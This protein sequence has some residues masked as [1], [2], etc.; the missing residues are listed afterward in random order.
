MIA[1]KLEQKAPELKG[2]VREGMFDEEQLEAIKK[3]IKKKTRGN[4]FSDIKVK[5]RLYRF[6][7]GKRFD[8]HLIRQEL[9][10]VP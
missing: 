2:M 7:S 10:I 4:N 3:W 6:L 1:Y 9:F 8:D 5:E